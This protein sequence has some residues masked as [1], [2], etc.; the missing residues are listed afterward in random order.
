MTL[1]VVTPDSTDASAR[2]PRRRGLSNAGLGYTQVLVAAALFG[3]T[4]SVAKIALDAG[5]GPARLTALRCTGAALGLLVVL[6]ITRPRL[7]RVA[8][9][10][11]PVLVV[12]ALCGAALIQWLYFVAID[13]LPVGVA[14]L[15]EFTAPVFVA[16]Y[17]RCV[18]RHTVD[19]RVW[20]ALGM[21]L[22][23]LSLVAD[24]W[25]GGGLDPIGV[26][27]AIGAAACLAA[28][29][30]VGKH[31]LG[32]LHPMTVTFWMFAL[33]TAFW[34]VAQPW[35][36]FDP[37]ILTMRASMLGT[38]ASTSVPVWM[39]VLWVIALGTLTPYA[40]EIASL[41]HLS[42]T[43]TGI[44]GMSEPVIA[45]AIAWVW[46][47][48]TLGAIQL[49]GAA[50]VLAGIVI[51]QTVEQPHAVAGPSLPTPAAP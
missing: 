49:V 21:S 41:G 19:R 28:F 9:R 26:G 7:L 16:L 43:T 15:L 37:S 5:V 17:S 40:L 46:L 44:V 8:W 12:L 1:T 30:L 13:R 2:R 24:V 29:Y 4:G 48:Q 20:L 45:A 47:G 14:L 11:L 3:F 31:A 51:A 25:G 6:V 38:F 34:S 22:A 23:G 10:D 42:P 50:V 27:A 18:L 36:S 33:A 39:A 35:W 32:R